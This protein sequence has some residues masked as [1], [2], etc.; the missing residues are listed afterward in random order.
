MFNLIQEGFI[1]YLQVTRDYDKIRNAPLQL[2]MVT[3]K[4]RKNHQS[5][6][7]WSSNYDTF[8]SVMTIAADDR[9]RLFFRGWVVP[10]T[11]LVFQTLSSFPLLQ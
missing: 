11:T 1:N 9:T 5:L 2:Q 7:S 3:Q 4:Q 8:L 10:L 6:P